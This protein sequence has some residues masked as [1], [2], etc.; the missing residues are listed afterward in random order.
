MLF[1]QRPDAGLFAAAA[2]HCLPLASLDD[3][4]ATA[5]YRGHVAKAMVHRALGEAAQSLTAA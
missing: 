1:D 2:E 3:A 4:Y 5:A